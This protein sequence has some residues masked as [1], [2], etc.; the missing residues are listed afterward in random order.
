MEVQKFLRQKGLEALKDDL[1]IRIKEYD[2]LIV[3]N[4]DQ[5]NSPKSHP[6][7]CECRGLILD[8]SFDVVS[9]SFDRF[10]NLG[11][12]GAS[13][14]DFR[15]S[16]LLEKLDGS[17]INIY[18]HAG[19]WH[20]A[21]R[22]TA[23]AEMECSDTGKTFQKLVLETLG[24]Q[25][26]DSFSEWF[27][28]RFRIWRSHTFIFE[29]IG[30]EN[31]VVTPYREKEL[32]LLAVRAKETGDYAP[33]D[34]RQ[35]RD[36][37]NHPAIRLPKAYKA[38]SYDEV[39]KLFG[40]FG[41]LDEGVVAYNALTGIR[42]KIKR[43]EYMAVHR[44]CAQGVPGPKDVVRLI[45]MGEADEVLAYF[46]E[47]KPDFD[48]YQAAYDSFIEDIE[49]TYASVKDIEVQKDFALAVKD[50]AFSSI[51]FRHRQGGKPIKELVNGLPEDMLIK[52]IE[53]YL[54]G[55]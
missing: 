26:C 44:L 32:V 37:F 24:F 33:A 13:S 15:N 41:P 27:D 53:Y 12:S 5:F 10:F 29:L 40:A 54:A 48:K 49:N 8:R 23:F 7:V 2:D 28:S 52:M 3:L 1:L 39:M 11:E 4:Y 42:I 25:S 30:P 34:M 31:R 17:L 19:R 50:C 47:F 46:P 20:A 36:T 35:F 18:F 14:F 21:T 22:G 6:I 43:E 9:R 51:L 16:V 38:D 55:S 45:A